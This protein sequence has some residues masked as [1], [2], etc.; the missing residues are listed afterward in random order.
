LPEVTNMFDR[1]AIYG[2]EAIAYARKNRVPSELMT[3]V[4]Q[5]DGSRLIQPIGSLEEAERLATVDA[6]LVRLEFPSDA[7]FQ[8]LADSFPTLRK[9]PGVSP[10]LPMAL[11]RWLCEG[12]A[13][14]GA[15]CAARFLLGVWNNSDWEAVARAEELDEPGCAKRFDVLEA[16]GCWDAEHR[17]A[18]AA[19]AAH[20]YWP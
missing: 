19:W 3:P 9:R 14:H 13:S 12:R 10:F 6:Q 5:D 8:V 4:P 2:A 20:P 1:H 11:L 18:F 15:A 7:K 17:H 16:I